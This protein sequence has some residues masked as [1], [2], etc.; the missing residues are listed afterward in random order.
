MISANRE[1]AN[2][3]IRAKGSRQCP[4]TA[5]AIL[6][7]NHSNGIP[8]SMVNDDDYEKSEIKGLVNL[9]LIIQLLKNS[10]DNRWDLN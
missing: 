9:N 4:S 5:V 1:V 3:W 2:Y 8:S 7:Y 6:S 10:A